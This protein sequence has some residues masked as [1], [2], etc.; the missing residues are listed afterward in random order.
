[1]MH[2]ALYKHVPVA[3]G[4]GYIFVIAVVAEVDAA[5]NMAVDTAVEMEH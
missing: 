1:M 3:E 2:C 4:V 5:E